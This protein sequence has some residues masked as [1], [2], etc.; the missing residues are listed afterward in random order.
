MQINIKLDATHCI[1]KE[2]N[3][4]LDDMCPF[5]TYGNCNYF[6]LKTELDERRIVGFPA[7]VRSPKC[8]VE[9]HCQKE[10]AS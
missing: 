3:G 8:V 6:R 5:Q 7:Y 9:E 1:W 10:K 4:I 2:G